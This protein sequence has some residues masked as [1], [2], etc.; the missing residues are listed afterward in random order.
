MKH[1]NI[2]IIGLPEGEESKQGI[3]NLFEE[4]LTE[5]FPNLVKEKRHTSP[6]SSENP[7]QV[8][9]KEAHTKTHHN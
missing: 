4:M 9:P 8:G 1:S 5:N 6:G 7:K 2:H 3:E